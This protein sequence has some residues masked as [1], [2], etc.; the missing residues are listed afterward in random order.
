MKKAIFTIAIGQANPMYQA[1]IHS[2]RLYAEKVG[3]DLVI[4]NQRQYE[5]DIDNPRYLANPAWC[6]KMRIGEL[7][8]DYDRV[9][10]LDADIMI[11]P[12]ARDVFQQYPDLET[13]YMLDEGK[14][15]DRQPV[16][17]D[18]N[19]C[20]GTLEHW[21]TDRGLAS[22]YNLG[23]M[24]ISNQ[25][26]LFKHT[27]CDELQGVCNKIKYYE[28]TYFN[29]LIQKHQMKNQNLAPEFNR[30]DLF[31]KQGYKQADFIHYANKGYS[32]SGRRREYQYISDFCQFY[33]GILPDEI[34]RPLKQQAWD[35]FLNKVYQRYNLPN[36]LLK[37]ICQLFVGKIN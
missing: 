7:L 4:T 28:Q 2:F 26:P 35:F 14:I 16:I 37:F 15:V 9:L 5:I 19:D 21:P 13:I 8:K 11:H 23:V 12:D 36:P 10:Y 33:Q 25:S 31:G 18:I 17:N 1:A 24:L 30:M 32:P 29:Y 22:Y 27:R 6:E 3:A 34:L 20:L